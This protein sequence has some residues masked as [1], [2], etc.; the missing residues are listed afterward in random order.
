MKKSFAI[1]VL[2]LLVILTSN[3]LEAKTEDFKLTKILEGLNSPWSL[4]FVSKNEV[5]I[6][7]KPGNIIYV[8]IENKKKK[9]V[10]H[11]LKILVHGQG[12]LLDVLYH[13]KKV[14]ISYSEKRKDFES[15]TSIAKGKY[16]NDKINF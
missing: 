1:L 8:N 3:N 13:N 6:T 10:K 4:S 12:G 11:N 5:L 16:S 15:S 7:E 14:F 9:K 2:G